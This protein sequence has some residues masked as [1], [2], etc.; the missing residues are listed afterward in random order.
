MYLLADIGNV[1][2]SRTG[3]FVRTYF[4]YDNISPKTP[5]K[6][7]N[8]FFILGTIVSCL[9]TPLYPYLLLFFLFWKEKKKKINLVAIC[10]SAIST[11][12][13]FIS[14]LCSGSCLFSTFFPIS[15][16]FRFQVLSRTVYS[17]LCRKCS[18]W[19]GKE[20]RLKPDFGIEIF[21]K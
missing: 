8:S 20:K 2:G 1:N 7:M 15:F 16:S 17:L 14:N 5:L 6:T 18:W 12:I 3:P 9:H 10:F 21:K 19:V 13:Y 11:V 4:R